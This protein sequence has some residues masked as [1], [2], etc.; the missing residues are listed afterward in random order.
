MTDWVDIEAA[1][2]ALGVKP[3]TLYAYVSRGLIETCPSP[4]HPRRRL[5]WADDIAELRERRTRSRARAAIATG[6]MAWGE[7]SLT[8]AIST[9][10]RERLIYRGR[11]AASMAES[12]TI[13]EIASLLWESRGSVTF[14]ATGS[15]AKSPFT[16]LA[17]L[18]RTSGPSVGRAKARLCRDA[19]DAIGA[20]ALSCGVG[21]GAV[22][23]HRRLARLWSLGEQEADVLR[24]TLVL[25]ADH[26][27][28][29]ST[30][31]TRVVASSGASLSACL[32]AG[33]CALSGPRHG[34]APSALA[35]LLD[36]CRD[37]GVVRSVDAWLDRDGNLP[38]FGH[39]LYPS[40]DV[41]TRSLRHLLPRDALM[42][43]VAAQ[44][45]AA[46]GQHPNVDFSLVAIARAYGLPAEAP[47]V[48]FLLGRS[49]GWA[50][51]AM[52]QAARKDLIR[53]RA[54]YVGP[55]PTEL[56]AQGRAEHRATME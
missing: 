32:L 4:S 21:N 47:F 10:Q 23:L 42:E 54:R 25:L 26:E 8:T 31:A 13:E 53:P 39:P 33:A 2:Q 16:A 56:K 12:G 34:N 55:T 28:N 51:H 38:G 37:R 22:P 11:D 18:A 20:V 45:M 50:A 36:E 24:R 52:E 27:L 7:P 41:R 30:F 46:A 14:E 43:D 40:G 5:Y 48:L 49:V 9:V 3:Q 1:L 17:Q 35:R 19:Q 15:R 29:V 6:S 44:V